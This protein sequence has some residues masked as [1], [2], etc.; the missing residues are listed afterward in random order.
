MVACAISGLPSVRLRTGS[1]VCI[2]VD[3]PTG[4]TTV[5]CSLCVRVHAGPRAAAFCIALEG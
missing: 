2:S 3:L 5:L 1:A 4:T